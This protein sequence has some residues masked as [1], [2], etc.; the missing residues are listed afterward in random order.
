MQQPQKGEK[1]M[2]VRRFLFQTKLGEM[3]LVFLER[4]VGLAVV[5]ADWL[6]AQRSGEPKHL[7]ETP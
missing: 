1:T 7:S 3:L 4:K 6:G 5:Q 2:F